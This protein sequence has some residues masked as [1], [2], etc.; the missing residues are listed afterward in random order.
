MEGP[1]APQEPQASEGLL[2]RILG[3]LRGKSFV[4]IFM[5]IAGEAA[6]WLSGASVW[7]MLLLVLTVAAAAFAGAVVRNWL[8]GR[9]GK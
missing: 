8:D 1:Q 3:I 7:I 9:H 5:L 2:G 6:L 4:L